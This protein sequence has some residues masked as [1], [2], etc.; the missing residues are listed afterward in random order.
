MRGH[1][2]TVKTCCARGPFWLNTPDA[3]C[4]RATGCLHDATIGATDRADSCSSV[5]ANR[6]RRRRRQLHRHPPRPPRLPSV[7]RLPPTRRPRPLFHTDRPPLLQLAA[8][9]RPRLLAGRLLLLR[10]RVG[11]LG[12]LRSGRVLRLSSADRRRTVADRRVLVTPADVQV[13][14]VTDDQQTTQWLLLL[15]LFITPKRHHHHFIC[16]IIQQYA[17]L[18]KY[19]SSTAGQRGPMKTVTAALKRSIKTVTWCTFYHT[20]KNITNEKN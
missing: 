6:R 20:S 8:L 11:R 2:K 18:R 7:H 4:R 14:E 10:A 3:E 5:A 15:L 1:E 9:L 17:H 13:L 16:P 12:H 19:D